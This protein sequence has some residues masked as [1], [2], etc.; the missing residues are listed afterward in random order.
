[1]KIPLQT[2]IDLGMLRKQNKCANCKRRMDIDRYDVQ[3]C[4]KC[5]KIVQDDMYSKMQELEYR[6]G[7]TKTGLVS[8]RRIYR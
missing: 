5:R 1:M 3:L 4:R 7:Q 2:I 6:E 8:S